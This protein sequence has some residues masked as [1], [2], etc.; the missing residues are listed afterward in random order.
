MHRESTSEVGAHRDK[1]KA[2]Y[3][4]R[5]GG[6]AGG[7][8]L[9]P[10]STAPVYAQE[11][12][13]SKPLSGSASRTAMVISCGL[14]CRTPSPFVPRRGREQAAVSDFRTSEVLHRLGI[15]ILPCIHPHPTCA[16]PCRLPEGGTRLESPAAC[17]ALPE[18]G[19][20]RP[21]CANCRHH[22]GSYP[23]TCHGHSRPSTD[24]RPLR[25]RM[26]PLRAQTRDKPR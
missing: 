12:R 25:L 20:S 15:S 8:R 10:G 14:W 11:E 21:R 3:D 13:N 7:W 6:A 1:A 4:P 9:R 17:G 22:A 18:N 23:A 2:A 16:R 5:L 24:R 19:G 26:Q